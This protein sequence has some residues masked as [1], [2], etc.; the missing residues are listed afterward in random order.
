[1]AFSRLCGQPAVTQGTGALLGAP[2]I[3]VVV[4]IGCWAIANTLEGGPITQA[5]A[6]LRSAPSEAHYGHTREKSG[7]G[8]EKQGRDLG[9][10]SV[11]MSGLCVRHMTYLVRTVDQE[12]DELLPSAPAIAIDG[13]KGVGKT[14]TAKRRADA[15]WFLDQQ[16]TQ[17]AA[18]SDPTFS[19]VPSGTLLLDEWQHC[20]Q[21]WDNVRRAVDQGA[22]ASRFLLT[23]SATPASVSGTHSGAGRVLSLRMRPM[24]FHERGQVEPTV[25]LKDVLSGNAVSVQDTSTFVLADYVKAIVDSGFP[26]IAYQP[27]H[28]RRRLLD[29]YL[30]RII[31]HDLPD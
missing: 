26:G 29:S 6:F 3:D 15:T 17:L 27:E 1:M 4:A 25:S 31:D 5:A 23:G 18:Q 20:P 14:D 13:P 19:T 28:L 30:A 21:V 22:P 7:C 8:L 12:L 11:G 9:N 2:A 16:E 24:A 10:G